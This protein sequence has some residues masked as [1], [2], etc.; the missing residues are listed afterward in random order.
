MRRVHIDFETRSKVN[1]F[2]AG[3]YRYAEDPST[4]ILCIAY[5]V[6]DE[7]VRIITKEM[8]YDFRWVKQVKAVRHLQVLAEDPNVIFVAHNAYFEQVI[9]GHKLADFPPLPP[10]RWRCTA[11][12]H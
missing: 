9:W 6:D 2:D 5:A 10:E 11:A 3:A 8:L 12:G 7:P 4:E 1:I